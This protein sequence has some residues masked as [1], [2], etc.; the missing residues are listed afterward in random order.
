LF[1]IALA[2]GAQA[3][4]SGATDDIVALDAGS[5]RADAVLDHWLFAAD[6]AAIRS[7][8]RGGVR[9]VEQGRHRHRERLAG[10]YRKTLSRLLA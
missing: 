2:G 1:E 10:R 3:V 9:L 7:V 5:F 6:N 8:E 4:G